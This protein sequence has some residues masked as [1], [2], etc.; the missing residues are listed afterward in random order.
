MHPNRAIKR[1]HLLLVCKGLGA[2]QLLVKSAFCSDRHAYARWCYCHGGSALLY[3]ADL[4]SGIL[5]PALH[6]HSPCL[7]WTS[8]CRLHFR[9]SGM[10]SLYFPAVVHTHRLQA[11]Q[12][13]D[14]TKL[15]SLATPKVQ[16]SVIYLASTLITFRFG[17]RVQLCP[18][19]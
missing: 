12:R 6:C 5:P 18:I 3:M 10:N 19:P 4:D 15:S 13:G 9:R 14:L 16:I 2:A 11:F 1:R 17:W 8:C 7:D